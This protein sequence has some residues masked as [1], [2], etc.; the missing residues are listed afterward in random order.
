[1][2]AIT[3]NHVYR[4]LEIFTAFLLLNIIWVL[5][6]LLIVPMFPAT[7]AMFGVVR[8]WKSEGIDD[9]LVKP[10]FQLLKENWKKSIKV[11]VIWSLLGFIL[12]VDFY[13]MNELQFQ[14]KTVMISLLLFCII[15]YLFTTI[16][17]FPIFVNYELSIKSILKNALFYSLGK[18]GTTLLTFVTIALILIIVYFFPMLLLIFGSLIAFTT[19]SICS[20][21]FERKTVLK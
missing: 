10:F 4:V 16:Y 18:I 1:M 20:N 15:L 12:A 21:S 5:L 13:L 3:R 2:I 6:C 9:G 14:G 17:L 8:K 7:A 11:G 19:Y